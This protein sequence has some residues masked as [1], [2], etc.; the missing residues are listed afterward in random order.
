MKG[1]IKHAH[2]KKLLVVV[3]LTSDL[4]YYELST[5]YNEGVGRGLEYNLYPHKTKNLEG[6]PRQS[7]TKQ[8]L[9]QPSLLMIRKLLR[10]IDTQLPGR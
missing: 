10:F 5:E 1:V 6:F 9:L 4:S 7:I 8:R 3:S 2:L